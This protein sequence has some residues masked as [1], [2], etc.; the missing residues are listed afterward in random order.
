LRESQ[1]R[2]ESSKTNNSTNTTELAYG[3][4]TASAS[5]DDLMF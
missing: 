1:D 5:S 2:Y 3:T 4:P